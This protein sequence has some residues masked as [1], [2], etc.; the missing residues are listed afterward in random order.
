MSARYI[1]LF[2][3]I[4]NGGTFAGELLRQNPKIFYIKEPLLGH[5]YLKFFEIPCLV[6]TNRLQMWN[7]LIEIL[8]IIFLSKIT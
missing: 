8:H 7:I 3:H 1:I 5:R 6:L 4:R 2:S